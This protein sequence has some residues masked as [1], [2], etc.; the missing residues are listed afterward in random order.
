MSGER[1]SAVVVDDDADVRALLSRF[2]TDT[3]LVTVVGEAAD[4]RG[5][6]E[7]VEASDPDVVLL[8]VR[9]PVMDGLEALPLVREAA[10]LATVVAFSGLGDEELQSEAL[11]A[12][13][14]AFLAKGV[15]LRDLVEEVL[16]IAGAP[17]AQGELAAALHLQNQ[18]LSGRRARGFVRGHLVRWGCGHLLDDAELLTTEL[19]NNAVLHT[20]SS[21]ELR[22]RLRQGRVRI[23][24]T[25]SGRGLPERRSGD[26]EATSGR[27][28]LLVAAM[29]TDWGA[30]ARPEGKTVWFELGDEARSLDEALFA[31]G[32]ER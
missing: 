4:G 18:P 25:D 9:M 5:A 6:I 21:I 20:E 26:L 12:G 13:A 32:G 7:V 10:P 17:S 30:T 16:S 27:G 22:V 11:S 2:L 3:G 19:V 14:T 31:P 8:D 24:V 23:A 28:L 1:L 15:R 29:A